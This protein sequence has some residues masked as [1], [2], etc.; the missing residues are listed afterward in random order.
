[1]TA[2]SGV[3]PIDEFEEHRRAREKVEGGVF[4]NDEGDPVEDVLGW[5]KSRIGVKIDRVEKI[6]G[7]GRKSMWHFT[8]EHRRGHTVEM[9]PIEGGRV[10]DAHYMRAQFFAEA[11]KAIEQLKAKEWGRI[12]EAFDHAAIERDTGD[13]EKRAWTER[14]ASFA[15][16]CPKGI[17]IDDP[18]VKADHIDT[19]VRCFI[20][21]TGTLWAHKESFENHLRNIERYYPKAGEV[22]SALTLLG[23]E[24]K[25]L[26][27][28]SRKHSKNV[29]R[30]YYHSPAAFEVEA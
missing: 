26:T 8:V 17:D 10:I 11:G 1:M 15:E 19:R 20:D 3:V 13:S 28:R 6:V 7:G 9:S 23:F 22:A 14:L 4:L 18:S 24:H 25:Q 5:V 16:S 12:A 27:A 30:W 2:D 21:T 29:A